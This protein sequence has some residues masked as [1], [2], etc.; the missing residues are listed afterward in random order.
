MALK[1]G[2]SFNRS[3]SIRIPILDG[4]YNIGIYFDK[5]STFLL[6]KVDAD[7]SSNSNFK[8]NIKINM[9]KNLESSKF[10][11]TFLK[12]HSYRKDTL[13]ILNQFDKINDNYI[14]DISFVLNESIILSKIEL[15][16]R[17]IFDTL[18][19]Y[20]LTINSYT[21]EYIFIITERHNI[22][23]RL[24]KKIVRTSGLQIATTPALNFLDE[25]S[26][27]I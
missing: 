27:V 1:L 7:F 20:G 10:C 21:E 22:L 15:Y 16:D 8:R 25:Y 2:R 14:H 9:F 4:Y 13:D 6:F 26:Q 18:N 23:K 5:K 17:E 3:Y 24:R 19:I 12:L 11:E